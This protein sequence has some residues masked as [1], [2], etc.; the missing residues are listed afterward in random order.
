MKTSKIFQKFYLTCSH[1]SKLHFRCAFAHSNLCCL[2]LSV[3]TWHLIGLIAG[4]SASRRRL[5]TVEESILTPL[6]SWSSVASSLEDNLGF[7]I[8]NFKKW[9][10]SVTDVFRFAPHLPSRSD[11]VLPVSSYFLITLPT[12][13]GESS[14]LRAISR[15]DLLVWQCKA[16]ILPFTKS[17]VSDIS[18]KWMRKVIEIITR[19][20]D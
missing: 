11:S 13:A 17:E 7:S 20:H 6:V 19:Y 5:R 4:L 15:P 1:F 16:T 3:S 12:V 9:R 2:I 14:R 18:W 8:D 10:S